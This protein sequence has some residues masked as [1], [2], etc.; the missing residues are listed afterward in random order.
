VDA[1]DS[2]NVREAS[3]PTSEAQAVGVTGSLSSTHLHGRMCLALAEGEAGSVA[4]QRPLVILEAVCSAVVR[5]S[6]ALPRQGLLKAGPNG[7]RWPERGRY[8]KRP[9]RM[10][11][12][13]RSRREGKAF[14]T[15]SSCSHEEVYNQHGRIRIANQTAFK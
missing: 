10:G 8:G 4:R 13:A 5:G 12:A 6:R 14:P 1:L 9:V 3:E 7:G 11:S 15:R 2:T